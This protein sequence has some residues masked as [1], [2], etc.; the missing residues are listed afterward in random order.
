M[1]TKDRLL[2]FIR[3]ADVQIEGEVS[4]DLSLLKSGIFDSIALFRLVE[5]IQDE[6]GAPVD[7]S[8]VE[9]PD[10]WDTVDDIVRFIDSRRAGRIGT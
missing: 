5:W 1:S 7:L 10:D 3:K 8:E 2:A 4:T 6:I 9:L